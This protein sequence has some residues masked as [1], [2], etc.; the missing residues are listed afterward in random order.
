MSV[1]S[2]LATVARFCVLT[3][4]RSARAAVEVD[5]AEVQLLVLFGSVKVAPLS[6]TQP[7]FVSDAAPVAVVTSVTV[8]V[9][10]PTAERPRQGACENRRAIG[11]GPSVVRESRSCPS[12]LA[13]RQGV[14]Y[15]YCVALPVTA[16]GPLLVACRTD[17]TA[18]P[19][20]TGLGDFVLVIDK[21]LPSR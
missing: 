17:V 15:G 1:V 21:S 7:W 12:S 8:G 2:V 3:I 14:R 16:R 19:C 11:A 10:A 9:F 4:L 20:A 18:A 5:A 13:G 6:A